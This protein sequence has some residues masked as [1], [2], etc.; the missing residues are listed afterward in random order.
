MSKFTIINRRHHCRSCG[1]VL[2]SSCCSRKASLPYIEGANKKAKVCIPCDI[3][4]A[5]IAEQE[6]AQNAVNST[7]TEM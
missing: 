2:C 7:L 6:N 5:R 4:L 3:T 1:R